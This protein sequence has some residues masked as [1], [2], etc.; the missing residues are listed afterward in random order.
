MSSTDPAQ[1]GDLAQSVSAGK[2]K[3]KAVDVPQ[4]VSMGEDSSSDEGTG[5]EDE[6][7]SLYL[8]LPGRLRTI[9]DR[10]H[11]FVVKRRA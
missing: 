8:E 1:G 9:A 7:W 10:F 2:G 11:Y 4:D 3:G 5:A 6:V